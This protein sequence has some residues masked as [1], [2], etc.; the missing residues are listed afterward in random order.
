MTK[1]APFEQ[2]QA[3]SEAG[4]S[5]IE[6]ETLVGN[7]K[8]RFSGNTRVSS[9]AKLAM[10]EAIRE[11]VDARAMEVETVTIDEVNDR[12][13]IDTMY[14]YPAFGRVDAQFSRRDEIADSV[15]LFVVGDPDHAQVLVGDLVERL[16]R[17]RQR[18]SATFASFW[19]WWQL[20]LI[21]L[22]QISA[23]IREKTLLG[24]LGDALIQRIGR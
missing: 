7:F 1:R 24:R 14:Y 12:I 20:G 21:V 9:Q 4:G 5:E 23:R 6:V 19:F 11:F 15:L 16:A 13:E 18:K 17:V 10:S 22:Y 8:F 3:M 2:T